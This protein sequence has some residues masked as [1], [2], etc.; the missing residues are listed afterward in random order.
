V[1]SIYNVPIAYHKEGLDE[2]VLKYFDLMAPK[3]DLAKW[4]AIAKKIALPLG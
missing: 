2:Q 3:P 1:S 4:Y